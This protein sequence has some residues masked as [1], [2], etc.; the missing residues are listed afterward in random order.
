LYYYFGP[1]LDERKWYWATPGAAAGVA[2]WLLASLGFRLYLHF[3]NSYSAAYG[4]LAAVI[5]LMLW[6]YMT[7]FAILIGGEVNWVIE[8]E[9]K[10]T[11]AFDSKKEQIQQRMKAA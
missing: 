8:N 5:I 7:G 2:L 11:A 6:L 3:F 4:S 9:D 1:N 10:K